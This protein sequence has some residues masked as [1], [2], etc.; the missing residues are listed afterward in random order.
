MV[1]KKALQIRGENWAV[2]RLLALVLQAGLRRVNFP[3]P[4]SQHH[5][6]HWAA[7]S[8][9]YP[10]QYTSPARQSHSALICTGSVKKKRTLMLKKHCAKL[11]NRKNTKGVTHFCWAS[12]ATELITSWWCFPKKKLDHQ[13]PESCLGRP[14]KCTTRRNTQNTKCFNRATALFWV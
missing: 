1:I 14:W 10:G 13:C 8:S 9:P 5:Y 6:S 11:Y 7:C 12:S 3:P 4:T 2:G